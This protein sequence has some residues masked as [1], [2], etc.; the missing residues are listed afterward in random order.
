MF[1]LQTSHMTRDYSMHPAWLS[2]Q[3]LIDIKKANVNIALAFAFLM[4]FVIY[5]IIS[6]KIVCRKLKWQCMIFSFQRKDYH[7]CNNW[8][9]YVLSW[10]YVMKRLSDLEF[11]NFTLLTKLYELLHWKW[12]WIKLWIIVQILSDVSVT[13]SWYSHLDNKCIRA[14]YICSSARLSTTNKQVNTEAASISLHEFSC[15]WRHGIF[16]FS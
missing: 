6:I 15:W 16:L 14:I 11:S 2:K 12:W 5:Y 13:S 4:A 1:M 9:S 10:L 3:R 7:L 8:I